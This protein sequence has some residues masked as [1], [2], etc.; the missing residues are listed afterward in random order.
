MGMGNVIRSRER[1][2]TSHTGLQLSVSED[3]VGET[4]RQ[5]RKAGFEVADWLAG[6]TRPASVSFS[7]PAA[8]ERGTTWVVGTTWPWKLF[9]G[10]GHLSFCEPDCFSVASVNSPETYP[11]GEPRSRMKCKQT[12]RASR[13][14]TS[15]MRHDV[16]RPLPA[17]D[18]SCLS[19]ARGNGFHGWAS[20]T[21]LVG[22]YLTYIVTVP[23][24]R[25]HTTPDSR[26][27]QNEDIS[28]PVTP[29]LAQTR[30]RELAQR[31]GCSTL[32][33]WLHPVLF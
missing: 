25:H 8:V 7:A 16:E 27:I 31:E 13:A 5:Q 12:C 17:M 10:P 20:R 6:L 3:P 22:T 4:R 28:S 30:G 32:Q 11:D 1:T 26:P 15:G 33:A 9:P 14:Y 23:S 19:S 18:C 29:C 21:R 2:G 24:Q